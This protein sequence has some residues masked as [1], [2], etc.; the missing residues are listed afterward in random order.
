MSK[1]MTAQEFES[2][3]ARHSPEEVR[4]RAIELQADLTTELAETV[5][6]DRETY[7]AAGV[8][9]KEIIATA[10]AE[11]W[12][13]EQA[14]QEAEEPVGISQYDVGSEDGVSVEIPAGELADLIDCG[15]VRT[16]L[17]DDSLEAQKLAQAEFCALHGEFQKSEYNANLLRDRVERNGGRYFTVENL[18]EAF[19]ELV[20][21]GAIEIPDSFFQS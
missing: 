10:G 8:D 14:Q 5:G 21:E 17:A 16:T 18:E 20:F 15:L 3:A 11:Q 1:T 6:I 19:R 13:D 2:W 7:E 9:E 12:L 4:D